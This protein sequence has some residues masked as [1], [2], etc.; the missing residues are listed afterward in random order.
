MILPDEI[1][2][3]SAVTAGPGELMWGANLGIEEIATV[4]APITINAGG[5]YREITGSDIL[6][7]A[8][9]K[10]QTIDGEPFKGKLYC[11]TRLKNGHPDA[12]EA[13]DLLLRT[14]RNFRSDPRLCL[15]DQ[16]SDGSFDHAV[17]VGRIISGPIKIQIPNTPYKS[18]KDFKI[19]EASVQFRPNK[20]AIFQSPQMELDAYLDGHKVNIAAIYMPALGGSEYK[21][22]FSEKTMEK[23]S[24]PASLCFGSMTVTVLAFDS[25]TATVKARLDNGFYR[26]RIYFENVPP[27]I[28]FLP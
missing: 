26:T 3:T 6:W 8:E 19:P 25:A 18:V 5:M 17:A 28:I 22:V 11:G 16:D 21:R 23:S 9:P 13:R 15:L 10:M 2:N 7:R 12:G 1:T 20:G 14:D 27:T 4:R 24:Y